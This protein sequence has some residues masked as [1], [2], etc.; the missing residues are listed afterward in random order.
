MGDAV[1]YTVSPTRVGCCVGASV[2]AVG[3]IEGSVGEI[4]GTVGDVV[5]YTV[6]PTRVGCLVGASLGGVDPGVAPAP[7]AAVVPTVGFAVGYI[8]SPCKV[9]L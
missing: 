8:V 1:G 4:L 6:S 9:G 5:G 2:R 7:A 3:A